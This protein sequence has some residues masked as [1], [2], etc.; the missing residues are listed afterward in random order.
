MAYRYDNRNPYPLGA[1]PEEGGI[2]FSFP[3]KEAD[4]GVLI[5]HS[6]TGKELRKIPFS[7]E[8]RRGIYIA[9]W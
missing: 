9:E 3:S 1:R 8:D 2:Y 7:G 5:Y 4:C 6:R